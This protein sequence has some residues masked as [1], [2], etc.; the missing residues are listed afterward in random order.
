MRCR[1]IAQNSYLRKSEFMYSPARP[2]PIRGAFRDRH[3]RWR[4]DAM[5]ALMRKTGDIKAD[6]EIAW[7]RHPDA[8]VNPRVKSPGGRGLT[9]PVPRGEREDKPLKPIAQGMPECFGV[10]V[11]TCLRA[12]LNCTQGCGCG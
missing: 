2:A 12:F 7:S 6:G 11:V 9:S 3:E 5:D 1:R 8:G 10:P 4:Q